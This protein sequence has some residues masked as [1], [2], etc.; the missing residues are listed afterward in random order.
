MLIMPVKLV[1]STAGQSKGDSCIGW[2]ANQS[3]G[4][5]WPTTLMA[6]VILPA[7]IDDHRL[8][9]ASERRSAPAADALA[10]AALAAC[11]AAVW[12]LQ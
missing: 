3:E 6:C 12:R 1:L 2:H 4:R 7:G 10:L 5:L 11:T 8:Y 9:L